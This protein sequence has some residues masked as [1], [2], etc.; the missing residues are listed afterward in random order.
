MV[1]ASTGSNT[2]K[3]VHVQPGEVLSRP[4]LCPG[5]SQP[6]WGPMSPAAARVQRW[7]VLPPNPSFCRSAAAAVAAAHGARA[8]AA[9]HSSRFALP[10][11]PIAMRASPAGASNLVRCPISVIIAHRQRTFP[12]LPIVGI[13]IRESGPS[14]ETAAAR[15]DN[16]GGATAVICCGDQQHATAECHE[17][18]RKHNQHRP[19][20]VALS[21]EPLRPRRAASSCKLRERT[22]QCAAQVAAQRAVAPHIFA[23]A[24]SSWCRSCSASVTS[25]SVSCSSSRSSARSVSLSLAPRRQHR[26]PPVLQR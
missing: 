8:C 2:A 19:Q 20:A 25:R 17:R 13:D 21:L 9:T 12:L 16:A 24:R 22:F 23:S 14:P 10:P 6:P 26:L 7:R 4:E 18:C 11:C 1:S 15:L 3:H 5:G